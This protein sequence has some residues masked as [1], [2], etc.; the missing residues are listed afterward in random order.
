MWSTAVSFL[1]YDELCWSIQNIQFVRL[2]CISWMF[3]LEK[4]GASGLHQVL[5]NTKT[6]WYVVFCI[7]CMFRMN[8]DPPLG[9]QYHC[10]CW[11]TCMLP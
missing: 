7:N 1:A 5:S 2:F 10:P 8:T 3:C 11:T 9:L 4:E 6:V